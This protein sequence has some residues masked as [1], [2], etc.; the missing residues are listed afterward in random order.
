MENT[1]RIWIIL[2]PVAR[3]SSLFPCSGGMAYLLIG[4][5][6]RADRIIFQHVCAILNNCSVLCLLIRA[7][8]LADRISKRLLLQF[9]QCH[10]VADKRITAEGAIKIFRNALMTKIQNYI[11]FM[12]LWY[13]N[14]KNDTKPMIISYCLIIV[15]IIKLIFITFTVFQI[16]VSDGFKK[17]TTEE[18]HFDF[19]IIICAALLTQYKLKSLLKFQA[20]NPGDETESPPGLT[21]HSIWLAP[22]AHRSVA[23]LSSYH[24]PA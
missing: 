18:F 13:T 7:L 17:T 12:L 6:Y 5:T 10:Q 14:D 19:I 21:R 11:T 16:T 8:M 20:R 9:Q 4:D 2:L 22:Y 3:R 15:N 24:L 1:K 23:F